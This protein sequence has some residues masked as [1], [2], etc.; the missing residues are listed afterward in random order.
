MEKPIFEGCATAILTPFNDD[1]DRSVNYTEFEKLIEF[2]IENGVN[3]IVVCGTTGEASTMPDSEHIAVI[4][5]CVEVVSHRVPVIAGT[6]S[7]DTAHGIHLSQEAEKA[8]ADALLQVTPYYNKTSQAGLIAH[9]KAVGDAVSVPM[10]LYNVP[11]RT[12]MTIAAETYAELAKHPRIVA[13]KEAS[14]NFT[15]LPTAMNL[16]RDS[17][18]FYSGNDDCILPL[19]S[20]GGKGVISVLSNVKPR[21]TVA[22]CKYALDG[23]YAKAADLQLSLMPLI[24]ALFSDV[25]PIPVKAA[26][27][28]MGFK[29][30]PVRLPLTDMAPAKLEALKALL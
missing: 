13:T 30:G 23:D 14:G 17:L 4:K 12:G 19:M 20:L 15:L 21:E 6:G 29:A 22:L 24:N 7:N 28:A 25:N 26:A 3:G 10:I 9:F 2:Q 27:N 8:G 5:Y 11:S 16:C 1:A 18:Y